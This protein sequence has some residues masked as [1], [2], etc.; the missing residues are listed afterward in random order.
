[1]DPTHPGELVSKLPGRPVSDGERER[2]AELLQQATSAGRI[3][4]EQYSMRVGAVWAADTEPE[5]A[6]ATEGLHDP[7]QPLVGVSTMPSIITVFGETVRSGRWKLPRVM[8]MFTMFGE[9][10]LDLR[11]AVIDAEAMRDGVVDVRGNTMFGA[12]KITVPEGVEVELSGVAVFG[13]RKITLAHVPRRPGTPLVRVH[14]N[15]VFGEVK[16]RSAP[17]EVR[18]GGARW[19]RDLFGLP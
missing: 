12:V 5:L 4:L 6:R 17:P 16:V 1:M 15:T 8:R 18:G 11:A 3:T 14:I 13:S 10:K 19:L 9:V 7:H 2:S